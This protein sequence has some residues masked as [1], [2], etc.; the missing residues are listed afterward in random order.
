MEQVHSIVNQLGDFKSFQRMII[1]ALIKGSRVDTCML[2]N[3]RLIS[4]N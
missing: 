3:P 2:L 4:V 1:K